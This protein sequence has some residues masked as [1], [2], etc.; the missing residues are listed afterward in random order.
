MRVITRFFHIFFIFNLLVALIVSIKYAWFPSE[1]LLKKYPKE[2]NY[3]FNKDG[4]IDEIFYIK[5]DTVVNGAVLARI[6]DDHFNSLEKIKI[7]NEQKFKILDRALI[8]SIKNGASDKSIQLLTARR[9]NQLEELNRLKEKIKLIIPSISIL[10]NNEFSGK[11]LDV[12]Y[13]KGENIIAGRTVLI[14][15]P[16]ES[17]YL[18]NKIISFIIILL[19]SIYIFVYKKFINL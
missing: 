19:F 13:I 18:T 16:Y 11:V 15:R 1:N 2:L 17:F 12:N 3:S 4:V 7:N 5:G 6:Y 10:Y 9:N 14:I 8:N